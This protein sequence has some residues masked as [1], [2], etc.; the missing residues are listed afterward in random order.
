M[1][2]M[3]AE[4]PLSKLDCPEVRDLLEENGYRHTDSWYMMDMIPFILQEQHS[5]VRGEIV[6]KDM[7]IIFDG[8]TRLGNVLVVVVRFLEEW[9][10]SNA[11]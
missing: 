9:T 11:L 1:E 6:G 7:S 4:I 3:E 10:V 2:L 5:Q 8:S